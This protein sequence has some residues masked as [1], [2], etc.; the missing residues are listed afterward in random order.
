[1]NKYKTIFLFL[2]GVFTSLMA[3]GQHSVSGKVTDENGEGLIG[4]NVIIKNSTNGTVTDYEGNYNLDVADAYATLIFSYVG[5]ATQE[6]MIAGRNTI[7]VILGPEATLINE[8][9]V[10]GYGTQRKSDV[11]GSV[12]SIK[13]GELQKIASSNVGQALQG[14]IAG[15]QV[16]AASGRPGEGPVI[17]IRGTGTLNGASPIFVVDGLILDN[18]DF[19]NT[20]D[21]ESLEVLKDASAAAIYGTRGANGVII[22]TTKKG[23]RGQKARFSAGSY[24]GQQELAKKIDLTNATEYAILANDIAINSKLQPPFADPESLGEGTDWQDVTY[25]KGII[26]NHNLSVSGGSENMA[27]NISGDIFR[28]EGIIHTSYY[29]RYSLRINNDYNFLKWLKFGHNVSFIASQNNQEPG[30]IVFNT[31]AADPTAPVRD[32]AGNYGNTSVN[33]NVSNPAAQLE[34]NSYN[35]DYRQFINGNGFAEIYFLKNFTLRSSLGFNLENTR[36]KS[37]TP[38]FFVNDKQRNPESIV[39]VSF[40]RAYDIQWES[41]LSYQKAWEN[42]RINLLAGYTTQERSSEWIG[43]SRKRLIS[44]E[45][46][47]YYLNAGDVETQTNYNL[48]SVPVK[49]LSTL[50]RLNYAFKD[51]YLFTGSFRRDGSSK[52]GKDSRNGN[53]ASFALAWRAIEEPFLKNQDILSNLKVRASWGILGNDK[54]DASAAVATVTN[55]LNAVFGPDENFLFGATIISLANPLLQWEE[56]TSA[57]AG[58]ELGFVQNKLTAEIDYYYRKTEKILVRV[59]I[60]NYVGSAND[61]F[62]NAADVKN[63]GWDLTLNWRDNIGKFSYKV[64][65]IG[66]TVQNEVLSLGRGRESLEAASISGEFATKTAIGHPIGSFFGYKVAGVYQNEEDI[67]KYPNRGVVKPGDLRFADLNG[68]GIIGTEDRT[69]LGSP[70]PDLIY[71]FNLAADYAGFDVAADFNGVS[72]NKLLN[73]KQTS[74]GFGLPNFE[75]SFLNRWTGE[76]SSDTEPRATNGGYPNYNVSDRFIEDGSFL[77]LRSLQVGYTL[78]ETLLKKWHLTNVRIYVSGNNLATWTDYSGYSPEISSE[79]VLQVGIDRG[80]YPLAK[81]YTAGINIGF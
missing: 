60:P 78:P 24:I 38:E 30:G 25:R 46:N 32:A 23:T 28:Q 48:A 15:V 63:I 51:K 42:H 33:S 11:T 79:N 53:F 59:P 18:I 8:V 19:L 49:Y 67:Q 52:F 64:G 66:S 58:V 9:V 35:R 17:R 50:F 7:D 75:S 29:N 43:G 40:S 39:N 68:D 72:G 80:I 76:G 2:I 41:T 37:F 16:T 69:Y 70:I 6:V 47:F 10:V 14:K 81:I 13:S 4:V 31:Y 77:R 5:F 56:A 54:I 12:S 71:G 1:M 62:V 34:Y 74:R 22:I 3:Y 44:N 20:A 26:Q 73:A 55:N 65:L 21:I 61:P 57:N 27:Y 36:G 45:E